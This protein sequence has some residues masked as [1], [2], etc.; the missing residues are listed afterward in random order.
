MLVLAYAVPTVVMVVVVSA[1]PQTE[2]TVEQG[3]VIQVGI[4][5]VGKVYAIVGATIGV[6][7]CG[8]AE[9]E[10]VAVGV[11]V[12]DTHAPCVS[13]H[14]YRTV[15][16][17]AIDKPAVLAAAENIHEVFVA[18]VEQIVVVVD[19]IVVAIHHIVDY[20]IHLIQEVKVDF[21]YVVVLTVRESQFVSHTVGKEARLA[22]DVGQTHRCITLCTD[23]CQSYKHH[24]Q[25]HRF[26]ISTVFKMNGSCYL[27][28]LQR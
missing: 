27:F 5:A 1:A 22:T 17:V 21:I 26:H 9:I 12:P 18:H 4:V 11:A 8:C 24:G 14:I 2:C 3:V 28:S 7:A 23:S 15:E 25:S 16:V 13:C 19:G 10:V 20:L 6:I